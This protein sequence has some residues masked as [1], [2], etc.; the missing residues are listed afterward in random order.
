MN[1]GRIWCVVNPT[2]GLPLLLGGVAVTS[3]IVHASIMEHT[4]WMS[5]YW[6]G[7]KARTAENV[8]PQPALASTA[9]PGFTMTVAPVAA[10]NASPAS[11]VIT[12][13]P[14]P[15]GDAAAST[16]LPAPIKSASAE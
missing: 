4:T 14:T 9:T 12:L 8:A 3:L 11:Y 1:Q 10:G 2:I 15:S 13:T 7:S 5:S 6:M 16:A